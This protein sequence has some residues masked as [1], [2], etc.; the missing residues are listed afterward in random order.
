MNAW[1]QCFLNRTKPAHLPPLE[2]RKHY[3]ERIILE[4][5]R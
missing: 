5:D 3:E 4:T 2:V 1:Y